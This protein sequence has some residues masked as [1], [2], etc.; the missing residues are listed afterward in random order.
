MIKMKQIII[1]SVI[2]VLL[3][4]TFAIIQFNQ[5]QASSSSDNSTQT[6]SIPLFS[7]AETDCKTITLKNENNE[8]ILKNN[9]GVW[10]IEN[11]PNVSSDAIAGVVTDII[12][13]SAH[14]Q[15]T[16]DVDD[17][18]AFGL[19][20]PQAQVT[21][22]LNDGS[23][24][25]FLLGSATPLSNTFYL[26]KEGDSSIYTVYS[27]VQSSINTKF[28]DKIDKSIDMIATDKISIISLKQRDRKE[29][30]LRGV[31]NTEDTQNVTVASMNM[32]Q[33]Y[34]DITLDQVKVNQLVNSL[35]AFSLNVLVEEN[36]SDFS[37][38]G[39]DDPKMDLMAMDSE[40][41]AVKIT[42]GGQD[43]NGQYYVRVNDGKLV[44]KAYKQLVEDLA[45]NPFDLANK[46]IYS[47][48]IDDVDEIKI[49]YGS[50]S[51]T[52]KIEKQ[53]STYKYSL[54]DS[55]LEEDRGND[56]YKTI[57][58]IVFDGECVEDVSLDTAMKIT[59]SLKEG[60][61]QTVIEFK[62]YDDNFYRVYV[63]E[64]SYFICSKDYVKS[65][66]NKLS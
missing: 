56:I 4:G 65:I 42:A 29:I 45:V 61:P 32:E 30:L 9:D 21:I 46:T 62:E 28:E 25:T 63:N 55:S 47:P 48:N 40:G 33:P 6:Q 34:K 35:K 49:E 15:I 39:F 1:A 3:I 17:L 53:D 57:T 27:G 43:E 19:N 12:N 2:L 24:E 54:N 51:F 44:Y 23:V 5:F 18:E 26:K 7:H 58:G 10:E 36:V 38:Y 66:I 14:N 11:M 41:K 64:T 22:E 52:Y 16:E 50:D 37:K 60:N 13:I 59:Y 31:F 8:Y 20:N